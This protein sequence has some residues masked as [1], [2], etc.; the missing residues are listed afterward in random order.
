LVL[1]RIKDGGVGKLESLDKKF[2]SVGGKGVRCNSRLG[3]GS[4]Y[5]TNKVT[6]GHKFTSR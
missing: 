6:M 1:L 2:G 5:D 3:T 4:M